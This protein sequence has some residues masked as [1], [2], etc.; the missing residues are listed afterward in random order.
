MKITYR[1][2]ALIFLLFASNIS[3][4]A[5]HLVGAEISYTFISKNKFNVMYKIYRDCK[6]LPLSAP[7]F[8]VSC[9]NGNHAT[10]LTASRTAI[11]DISV[12]CK[13]AALPCNPANTT[14]STGLEE[15]IYEVVVDFNQAPFST[16]RANC[17]KALFSVS[18]CCRSV[19][20]TNISPGD[21]YLD[22][23]VDLCASSRLGNTSPVFKNKPLRNIC[24]NQPLVLNNLSI[25]DT[26][27]DSLSFELAAPMNSLSTTE[28]YTGNFNA[29]IPMT[30]YCPPNPGVINCRALPAA[31]PPRGFYFDSN[32]GEVVLTPTKCDEVAVLVFKTTEWRRDSLG[33]MQIIGYVKR[34]S[35][36]V[37]NQCSNNNP[38][39][40][41]GNTAYSVCEGNKLCFN[42]VAQDDQALPNQTTADTVS[43]SW[44]S[45]SIQGNIRITNPAAREKTA[46]F[47][48]TPEIGK[49]RDY[50]YTFNVTASDNN[51]GQPLQ[52]FRTLSVQ[53]KPKAKDNRIYTPK[54]KGLLVFKAIPANSGN[55]NPQN[56]TYTFTLR[57]SSNTGTPLYLSYKYLDSFTFTNAGIYIM[58][59]T[60]NNPPY[61]CPTV[62]FDTIRISSAHLLKTD[63]LN[64]FDI[65]IYPNPGNGEINIS[66]GSI[67][68]NA[69]VITVY[70]ADGKSMGEMILSDGKLNLAFLS[71]GLYLIEI[72]TPEMSISRKLIIE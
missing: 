30:P 5:S 56:Y 54:F 32:T 50:P 44:D 19:A 48:W 64:I 24:C 26:D 3:L 22:A 21:F 57:D 9:D 15:H 42:I 25:D 52:A 4:F 34:E 38:P 55:Y 40:F 35:T 45:G 37:V 59:H 31:K 28:T 51:C 39:Y 49:A 63:P 66:S 70:S 23:M 7:D 46:E 18:T 1:L 20:I 65:Q 71:K 67:D 11:N 60:I 6:E 29:S 33:N 72:K 27:N 2:S 61:N 58:E 13:T 62:Y 16:I 8:K 17:C 69:A 68:L 43:L 41:E 47:C 12:V 36:L 10:T 53:V 14:T